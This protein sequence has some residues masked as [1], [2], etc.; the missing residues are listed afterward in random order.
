MPTSWLPPR[1]KP[2]LKSFDLLSLPLFAKCLLWLNP[3][4]LC[5]HI[6]NFE[7]SKVFYTKKCG[8]SHLSSPLSE[9]CLHWIN[10]FPLTADVFYGWPLSYDVIFKLIFV[11]LVQHSLSFG[12]RAASDQLYICSPMLYTCLVSI[13]LVTAWL[14]SYVVFL[15]CF[16]F[17]NAHL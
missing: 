7:K 17:A 12:L 2:S 10:P 13:K 8:R 16:F 5:G 15:I 14:F 1:L 6:I 11:S 4:C 9:K 3:L